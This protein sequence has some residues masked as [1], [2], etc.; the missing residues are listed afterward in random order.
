[1][2]RSAIPSL[3]KHLPGFRYILV[4]VFVRL[5]VV[6]KW[7]KLG[8]SIKNGICFLLTAYLSLHQLS[9]QSGQDTIKLD[10]ITIRE[11]FFPGSNRYY[12]P[13]DT[14]RVSRKYFRDAGTFLDHFSPVYI[15]KYG[16]GLSYSLSVR[17]GNSAQV[18]ILWNGVPLNSPMQG[19]ADLALIRF[20]EGQRLRFDPN[21]YDHGLSGTLSIEGQLADKE[22]K[23]FV[24]SEKLS[25]TIGHEMNLYYAQ[26]LSS[27]KYSIQ[28]NLSNNK[29][30]FE[31]EKQGVPATISN[32]ASRQYQGQASLERKWTGK[33]R[34]RIDGWVNYAERQIPP[35]L[36]E[37]SSDAEQLDQSFRLNASY[38]NLEKRSDL[39]I[40]S[41]YLFDRLDYHSEIRHIYSRSRS[42]QYLQQVRF[43]LTPMTDHHVTAHLTNRWMMVRSNAYEG[44]EMIDE[45]NLR[46]QHRF[47]W[48][49]KHLIRYGIRTGSRNILSGIQWAPHIHYQFRANEWLQLHLSAGRKF[50]YPAFNDL[51]WYPGGNKELLPEEAIEM[52]MGWT[53]SLETEWFLQSRFYLKRVSNWIQW[54]PVDGLFQAGNI[55]DVHGAGM[56]N[57]LRFSHEWGNYLFRSNLLHQVIINRY[58]TG[59]NT[60]RQLIYNP[61]SQVKSS[62]SLSR[63]N[64]EFFLD[65]QWTGKVYTSADHSESLPGYYLFNPGLEKSFP[66]R[67]CRL[68][69]WLRVDNLFNTR[70]FSI[71]NYV[72]PG[73]VF[74]LG[75]ELKLETKDG[76]LKKAY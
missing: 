72:M 66:L 18:D 47:N 67:S 26:T 6:F 30:R 28:A 29:N 16:P 63:N 3:K 34:L 61:L 27:W 9:G 76:S 69:T 35:S 38:R 36:F 43:A 65:Q 73:R 46:L 52:E 10:M 44:L 2:N 37:P 53:L 48:G 42:D 20:S 58:A 49:E 14:G 31:Y 70:Y 60:G 1:M 15:R 55:A 40:S 11:D 68:S 75:I 54:I 32:H 5:R 17:G 50:R 13:A 19:Q 23:R 45:L 12:D 71:Q 7:N 74:H 59:P 24:F 21:T 22:G 57:I 8:R 64:W 62:L 33:H 56:E 25:S 39:T 4:F 41:A 51:F